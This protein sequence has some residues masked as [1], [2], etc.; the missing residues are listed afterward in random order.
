[1]PACEPAPPPLPPGDDELQVKRGITYM[2]WYE[3]LLIGIAI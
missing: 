1:M 3:Y 2:V